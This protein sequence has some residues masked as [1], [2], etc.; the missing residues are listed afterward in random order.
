M[1]VGVEVQV[2]EEGQAVC[3]S[4]YGENGLRGEV[5]DLQQEHHHEQVQ[6]QAEDILNTTFNT[7]QT[8]Y[9]R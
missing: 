9:I 7:Q 1:L 2:A 4:A 3:S 6:R 8:C 5:L